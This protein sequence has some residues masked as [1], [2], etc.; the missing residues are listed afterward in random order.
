MKQIFKLTTLL[1]LI[2]IISSGAYAQYKPGKERGDPKE[3]TKG[4]MEGNRVRT[5]IFNFGQTGREG[6]SFPISVQTPYEWPKNTG[7]VYLALTGIFVGGEVQ[8]NL[9]D[10]KRIIDV[11]NYRTSPE[12]KTWNFEPVPG[13]YNKTANEIATSVNP[14]TWPAFWP[15]KMVDSVDPGWPGSWNGYFGKN[16]FNADQEMFFRYSDDRYDRYTEYFPDST[17][18]TRKGL[19][20]LVDQRVLAWSQILVEDAVFI[21]HSIKNDGTKPIKKTG[22][23]IWYADFVGGNGDSQDDVSEFELLEDIAWTRD[24][25]NR[26][27]EFGSNPVG[28]VAVAFLETPGN[29]LDRI[30]NDG[31]GE[32]FGPK[33][34]EAMLLGE[35]DASIS[36]Q[37]PRRTDG[38]D[39]NGNGLI[40]ENKTHI[41]F[42]IQVGVTYADY[43][44]QNGDAESNAPVVTAEMVSLVFSDQW[45]RWPADPQNDPVQNGQVHLVMV[46]DEDI[47]RA[48]RDNIDN[49]DDGEESSPVVTQAMIDQA[50]G[51]APYFRYK[52]PGTSIILYDLKSEDLG[53]KYADG[54][55]NN[56]DGRLDEFMD[57]GIDDMVD[58][59]RD[60]GIDNDGDWNILTDD[61]GLDGVPQTG[62]FGEEDGIPTSG[63]GTGLPGEPN[64]DL[65]DVSETDQIGITN[66]DYLAAGGLNINNDEL[67]WFNFIIPGKFYDP[68]EVVAGEYDLFVSSSYFPMKPGQIEPISLAVLFAN[69]PLPDPNS[70]LRKAEILKKRDRAQETYNNDYQF[71][72]APITPVLTAIPGDNKVTLYWDSEAENTFDAY[73][74]A[75]GGNG[76]DFEG[77]R[78]YRASDPAF[79]DPLNITTAN[80]TPVFRI[81]IAIFDLVDGIKGLDSIGFEGV[82]YNL[83]TDSGLKHSFVDTTALN[84]FTYYYAVVS[85]DFGFPQGNIIPTESPI[86]VSL[87][88]D[89]GVK[90]G[91]NV[92]RV[93]PEAPSAGYIQPTLG[94]IALESG[95]TTGKVFYDIIDINKIKDG[96]VYK[97]SFE[98]TLKVGGS[99]KPDTLTTKNFTLIDSTDNKV[100]IDKSTELA[101]DFEQPLIDGFRLRFINESRVALN[102]ETSKWNDNN[103]PPFIF[104]KFIWP[105]PA[106]KGQENPSD[107]VISFGD[108]G[109]GTSTTFKLGTLT[110]PSMPVNFKVFNKSSNTEIQFGFIERD[111]LI[112][113][114]GR[115]STKAANKDR[116]VFLE[117]NAQDSL[118]FTWWFFL[119]K[120]PVDSLN[121]EIPGINDTAFVFLRKPFLSSDVFRFVAQK[122]KIDNKLA[123]EQLNLIK[124][125]PN[126]YV[127]S[128]DWEPKNP[129]QSGRGPRS[130]HFTHLP[131]KCTIRIFTVNGELVDVIDHE[132][133]FN[134]GSAEWDMLSKDNLSISYGVYVFHIDAPGIGEKIGKFAVIK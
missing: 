97:I 28:M 16:K 126:P 59:S 124:V 5:S 125:V 106:L 115:L 57:E 45:K 82:K 24:N 113:G 25:D 131:N 114:K 78:I 47:G 29:A 110:F 51:D 41:P 130:L 37:D 10:T 121:Q 84:G 23:T 46:E 36:D 38:I 96:H 87:Q 42:G 1:L 43:I 52:V 108:V 7:Q 107:Y 14:E 94:N 77:Y 127:A 104:D 66:A 123:A 6:G 90:L 86:R 39:N 89:G 54:I 8:D 44:D 26:A 112:G 67:M 22:V 48:F 32:K 65:T 111:T 34:T 2:L 18:N 120:Q 75:I 63:A 71:A 64:V 19:G 11:M 79:L 128:A 118:V 60:D 17:D 116:I 99:G 13:Y 73:I 129:Y 53:K 100:L 122:G 50:A 20:I 56:N 109:F 74:D 117:K 69:G 134:D 12:G 49:D 133:Q 33:V 101:A 15:D 80:G 40:D 98:D 103:I 81:P 58:E 88:P 76:R 93:T 119:D 132:S 30:D 62:D 31:D 21:L 35:S 72:N 91:P 9:G 61:V 102:T 95:T 70:E 83:G 4:Q 55:D 3:R 92:V 68:Q 85:Y 27:P 105:S